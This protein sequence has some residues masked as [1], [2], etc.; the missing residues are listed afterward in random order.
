MENLENK[1]QEINIDIQVKP[2]IT[3]IVQTYRRPQLLRRTINSLL[4]QTYTN[5][6]ICVYDNASGDE[7]SKVVAEFA[8]KDPRVRYHCHS[9]N[10]GGLKNFHYAIARVDTPFFHIIADDDWTLPEF[11]KLGIVALQN[12]KEAKFFA[13]L[14]INVDNDFFPLM[15]IPSE[16]FPEGVNTPPEGMYKMISGHI[17][18]TSMIFNTTLIKELG[19]T[20]CNSVT[21]DYDFEVLAA[22]KYPFVV[23][24]QPCAIYHVHSA[25]GAKTISAEDFHSGV[26]HLAGKLLSDDTL[27]YST[28]RGIWRAM[29]RQQ[30]RLVC[31]KAYYNFMTQQIPEA[32]RSVAILESINKINFKTILFKSFCYVGGVFPVFYR[33][34]SVVFSARFRYLDKKGRERTKNKYGTMLDTLR[35]YFNAISEK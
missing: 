12:H 35:P 31:S 9:E 29:D 13:G 20:D 10:I 32:V 33:L 4:N 3:A 1:K 34:I 2:M 16:D 25:N 14:T 28:Q 27:P 15:A 24:H 23:S 6:L 21:L 26:L 22:C 19:I 7:T 30:F 18:W 5:L 8:Q 11:Y 17:P